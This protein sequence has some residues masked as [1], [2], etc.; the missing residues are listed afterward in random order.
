MDELV[1]LWDFWQNV[2]VGHALQVLT[3]TVGVAIGS[4]SPI[5]RGVL[6]ALSSRRKD[7]AVN[8]QALAELEAL[9]GALGEITER[10]DATEQLLK[11][12]ADVR[13][14]LSSPPSPELRSQV[15]TPH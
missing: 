13:R 11:A 7:R 1:R 8:E 2:I 14:I 15:N 12:Q 9:S 6:G 3:L 4:L 10:L 5:V